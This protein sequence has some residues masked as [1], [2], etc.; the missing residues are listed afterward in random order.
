MLSGLSKELGFSR[1]T[2]RSQQLLSL[3]ESAMRKKFLDEQK[4]QP[5]KRQTVVTC[6]TTLKKSL[7]DDDAVT[8]LVV[9]TESGHVYI[10]DSEA[11]TILDTI[12]VS[13]IPAFLGAVGLRD[14]DYR[15]V[16]ACRGRQ[17][18]QIKRGWRDS[19]PLAQLP[20][21]VLGLAMGPS[22]VVAALMDDTLRAYSK[23]GKEAWSV[24]LPKPVRCLTA[25]PLPQ[26]GMWASAVGMT[27]GTIHL[28]SE[29]RL[30]DTI[31]TPKPVS[32]LICGTFGQ[33]EHCLVANHDDGGLMVHIL[34]RTA[35]FAAASDEP[36]P[37][38]LQAL[39]IPKKTKLFVE[40]TVRERE[41]AKGKK[42]ITLISAIFK[43]IPP[44]ARI[45][46]FLSE[47][48]FFFI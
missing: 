39:P 40:Q 22:A 43:L 38:D 36:D 45:C 23:K 47:F 19:R 24:I 27:D 28:Y 8:C 16:V 35:S 33:G 6:L 7:P 12:R 44:N 15:I 48:L 14:V 11:F 4:N 10:L 18:V 41:G 3:P 32:A 21:Q 9:G 5:L 1:L 25:V 17:L 34:R 31:N 46:Y 26:H 2:A 37:K 20:A 13:G 30:I 42:L 29:G